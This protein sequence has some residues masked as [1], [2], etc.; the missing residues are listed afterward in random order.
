MTKRLTPLG[1][2]CLCSLFCLPI[3]ADE[4]TPDRL[5]KA[6]EEPHNWLHHHGTYN[7]NRF[8]SLK[9]INRENIG[10]LKV[11]WTYALG[12][13]SGGAV[14]S[15]GER[16]VGIEQTARSVRKDLVENRLRC[17]AGICLDAKRKVSD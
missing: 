7:A 13:T 1:L 12:G 2:I 10:Q 8:S 4:T 9:E 17:F 6:D 5:V 11:A 14:T 16:D 3:F 15:V